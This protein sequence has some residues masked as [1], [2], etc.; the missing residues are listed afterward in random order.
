MGSA[1]SSGLKLVNLKQDTSQATTD[2]HGYST[3]SQINAELSAEKKKQKSVIK[4][5]CLGISGS[6]KSTIL[7][8]MRVIHLDGFRDDEK[9]V[10]R[11]SLLYT[12]VNAS[13]ELLQKLPETLYDKDIAMLKAKLEHLTT[14]S[15][16]QAKS[17]T[18]VLRDVLKLLRSHLGKTLMTKYAVG[19]QSCNVIQYL[20]SRIEKIEDFQTIDPN[21][22]DILRV[23]VPTT[24]VAYTYFNYKKAS[25]CMI[26]VGGQKSERRKWIHLFDDVKAVFFVVDIS[27]FDSIVESLAVFEETCETQ[28]LKDASIILFFNKVD[29]FKEK[30]NRCELSRHFPE[31]VETG[32]HKDASHFVKQQFVE[33]FSK[34]K[35]AAIYTFFTCATDTHN[36]DKTFSACSD[37]IL[38]KSLMAAGLY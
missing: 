28:Y 15:L 25:L 22:Q 18:D 24:G 35:G 10:Y 14:V 13:N 1:P 8:Q 7:K 38:K 3:D 17:E 16:R 32:N 26:D 9:E 6:G 21:I 2:Q 31:Y 27:H 5:L 23:R 11:E 20:L 34:R 12:Y 37:I 30:Q 36:I 4:I 19:E 29:L 33:R